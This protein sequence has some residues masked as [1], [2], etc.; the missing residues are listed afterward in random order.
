MEK[1]GYIQIF[2]QNRVCSTI[3]NDVDIYVLVTGEIQY[4]QEEGLINNDSMQRPSQTKY[5]TI[6]GTYCIPFENL[7]KIFEHA[8]DKILDACINNGKI[9]IFIEN[10][11]I[12]Y[13]N[14]LDSNLPNISQKDI[15]L[16]A[17]K[18]WLQANNLK[19]F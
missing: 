13:T 10:N 7:K 12:L 19:F 9:S 1:S 2:K 4:L 16:Q 11:E 14:Y 8:S 5:N 6:L 3:T 15:I 18:P 17:S